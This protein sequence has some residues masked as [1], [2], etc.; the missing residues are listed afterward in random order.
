MK[1]K[2]LDLHYRTE[3]FYPWIRGQL[4]EIDDP[5]RAWDFLNIAIMNG[6][7]TERKAQKIFDKRFPKEALDD[8]RKFLVQTAVG[9]GDP[10]LEEEKKKAIE[11]RRKAIADLGFD[12]EAFERKLEEMKAQQKEGA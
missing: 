10:I 9:N 2:I 3:Y 8:W 6:V 11:N 4:C 7:I 1:R 5:D 12:Q